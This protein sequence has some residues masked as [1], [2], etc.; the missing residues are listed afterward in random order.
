PDVSPAA[1]TGSPHASPTRPR[2]NGDCRSEEH[3]SEL[4]SLTNLVCRL[5][6]EKKTQMANSEDVLKELD[7]P[8]AVEIIAVVVNAK[9]AERA[10]KTEAVRTLGFPYSLSPTFL[11]NNHRQNREAALHQ[12]HSFPTQPSSDLP[13]SPPPRRRAARTRRRRGLARTAT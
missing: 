3:T 2:Q 9:R 6:L 5:L 7:P 4:Q 1:T 12:L 11:R 10:I 8:E 13:A